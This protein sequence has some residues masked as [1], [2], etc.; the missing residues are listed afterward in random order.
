MDTCTPW[1]MDTCNC[2][3]D[4]PSKTVLEK[5][6]VLKKVCAADGVHLTAE[7]YC[8]AAKNISA[9]LQRLQAGTLG[10]SSA[11]PR[12]AVAHVSDAA[13]RHYW[14]G[15]SSPHGSLQKAA[16]QSWG[17]FPKDRHTGYNLPYK[18]WGRGGRGFWKN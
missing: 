3:V 11:M 1:I 4:A 16:S 12:S 17:K 10:K 2:V 18:R 7:G 5:L 13:P 14:K 15:F 6:D 9:T 8:N